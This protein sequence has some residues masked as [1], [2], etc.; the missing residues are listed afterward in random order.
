MILIEKGRFDPFLPLALGIADA[1]GLRIEEVSLRVPS[2]E[3][4]AVDHRRPA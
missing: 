2:G 1:F 4:Q 3:L